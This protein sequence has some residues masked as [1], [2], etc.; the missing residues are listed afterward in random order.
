MLSALVGN[1][2]P[3]RANGHMECDPKNWKGPQTWSQLAVMTFE[4]AP[5]INILRVEHVGLSSEKILIWLLERLKDHRIS[6]SDLPWKST[7]L[8]LGVVQSLRRVRPRHNPMCCRSSGLFP[9][10]IHHNIATRVCTVSKKYYTDTAR[11]PGK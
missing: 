9:P 1:T 2:V 11:N 6:I 7:V 8:E 10:C 3:H 5:T 4:S